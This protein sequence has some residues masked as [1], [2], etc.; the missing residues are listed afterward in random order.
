[1]AGSIERKL[2]IGFLSATCMILA[3]GLRVL[4]CC[5]WLPLSSDHGWVEHTHAVIDDIKLI[6][7]STCASWKAASA[8]SACQGNKIVPR[9]LSERTSS[10]YPATRPSRIAIDSRTTRAR[11]RGCKTL[12]LAVQAKLDVVNE[13]IDERQRLGQRARCPPPT[14]TRR[15]STPWRRW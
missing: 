5:R 1:M 15:A 13:R 9:F 14:S 8:D 12:R 3:H 11:S 7:E 10:C 6:S 4:P 2:T